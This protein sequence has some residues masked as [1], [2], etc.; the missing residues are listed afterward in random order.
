MAPVA[1]AAPACFH[2]F[3]GWAVFEGT[4]AV[5]EKAASAAQLRQATRAADATTERHT[6]ASA[7]RAA[8]HRALGAATRRHAR[9]ATHL[10]TAKRAVR[11]A[12]A[13]RR[14]ERAGGAPAART[15]AK[16]AAASKRVRITRKR[17]VVAQ[18][19]HAGARGGMVAARTRAKAAVASARTTR[20]R[21]DAANATLAELRARTHTR[22]VI[23]ITGGRSGSGHIG[24]ERYGYDTPCHY[25]SLTGRAL[26]QTANVRLDVLLT[27]SVAVSSVTRRLPG[28]GDHVTVTLS[29]LADMSP[30]GL[31][32]GAVRALANW[33]R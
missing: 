6:R 33:S 4:V 19:R 29:D 28:P 26:D 12:V 20:V 24:H 1:S 21:M 7:R 32:A 8:T 13:K 10:R 5:H 16:V 23:A 2:P 11:V 30:A 3:S 22:Y 17:V 25:L 9:A 18:R 31:R 14:V 27:D 15:K